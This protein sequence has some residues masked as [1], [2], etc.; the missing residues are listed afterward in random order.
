M[1]SKLEL[2]KQLRTITQAGMKDCSD[3]IAESNGDLEKAIDIIKTKGLNIT[4]G[5]EGRVAS[6]GMLAIKASDALATMVEVN[7]QTDF[8]ARSEGFSKFAETVS[9]NLYA[10][11][12]VST[13]PFNSASVA[14]E[15]ARNQVVSTTKENVVVRRWWIEEGVSTLSKI[16][17]Y[18]HSNSQIGVLLTLLAPSLEARNS[19]EFN[20]LGNDLVLQIAAMKPLAI[21]VDRLDPQEVERQRAIFIAQL[22]EA[23]KPQAAWEKII[24]GKFNKWHTDVCLLDQES[25]I[26]PKTSITQTIQAVSTKLG[27]TVEVVNFI[28]AQV[29]EGI[30]VAPKEDLAAVVAQTLEEQK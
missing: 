30:E 8:T 14:L 3:A 28:R 24:T 25:V 22:T 4:S 19:K 6:E 16:F 1:M 7:C 21:S 2:I 29:G 26:T 12:A 9:N 5:R 17:F 10:S 20:D 13:E 18:T 23:K 27:G 15:T 11:A